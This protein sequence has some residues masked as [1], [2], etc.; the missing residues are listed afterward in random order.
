[1]SYPITLMPARAEDALVERS[2]RRATGLR[3][4]TMP[5]PPHHP[6]TVPQVHD[7]LDERLGIVA[8][9]EYRRAGY[10]GRTVGAAG[11]MNRAGPQ[12]LY[13]DRTGHIR[14]RLPR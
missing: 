6:L 12:P 2:K 13:P 9:L 1:V 5:A 7:E 3:S 8:G 11:G 4:W 14:R 10:L